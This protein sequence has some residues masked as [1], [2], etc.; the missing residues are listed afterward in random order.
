M[1]L[2]KSHLDIPQSLL[3]SNSFEEDFSLD[4]IFSHS[5]SKNVQSNI[6]CEKSRV[7]ALSSLTERHIVVP[8]P[9]FLKSFEE[10]KFPRLIGYTLFQSSIFRNF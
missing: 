6:S 5:T 1:R 3:Q 10:Q 8:N 9:L 2:T 4:L 7:V